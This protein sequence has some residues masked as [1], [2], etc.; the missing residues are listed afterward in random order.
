MLSVFPTTKK[1]N[2]LNQC[3]RGDTLATQEEE[4]EGKENTL[5]SLLPTKIGC[6]A[7]FGLSDVN[8]EGARTAYRNKKKLKK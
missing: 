7:W 8:L 1:W 2:R 4:E 3:E 5:A 6:K